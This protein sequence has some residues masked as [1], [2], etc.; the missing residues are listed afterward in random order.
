LKKATSLSVLRLISL[1]LV[2]VGDTSYPFS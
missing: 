2:T 1:A